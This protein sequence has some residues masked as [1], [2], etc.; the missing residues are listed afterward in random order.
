MKAIAKRRAEE[1]VVDNLAYRMDLTS[2]LLDS[3]YEDAFPDSV[4]AEVAR[5]HSDA[6]TLE[7]FVDG[8]KTPTYRPLKAFAPRGLHRFSSRAE[9]QAI[10]GI[11]M[12]HKAKYKGA[13]E[14]T[15]F[16][17]YYLSDALWADEVIR[18]TGNYTA[19]FLQRIVY[20]GP[21]RDY[22]H[23]NYPW[24]GATPATVG[25]RGEE[26]IQ[27]L[28]ADASQ[29]SPRDRSKRNSKSS[30]RSATV[31]GV[32]QWLQKL[33]IANALSFQQ[34]GRGARHLGSPD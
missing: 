18:Q 34:V 5:G 19:Q 31:E 6:Y 33:G 11:K 7:A 4:S 16:L 12:H 10:R 29:K 21:L 13:R 22:P 30:N 1:I 9:F 3:Q 25:H 28:L 26:A 14:P 2:R 8:A 15:D 32:T 20:L 24:T 27:V 17:K 23:R